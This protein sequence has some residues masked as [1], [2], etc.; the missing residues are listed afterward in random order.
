MIRTIRPPDR[1]DHGL[2]W[3][4]GAYGFSIHARVSCEGNQKDRREPRA[5]F[6][7]IGMFAALPW[8]FLAFH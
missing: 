2:E 3:V 4:V 5:A 7:F 8:R 1:P 6:R